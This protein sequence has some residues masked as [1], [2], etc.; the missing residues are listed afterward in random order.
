M[1]MNLRELKYILKVAE[2]RSVTGAANELHISQPAL[3]RYIHDVEEELGAKIFDRSTT[4]ISLT[5]AGECYVQSAKRIL[6]EH[7]NL[8]REIRDITNHMAGRLRIGT[9]RDRASFMMPK[10][11]PP[12]IAKYPGIETEIFTES[13]QKLREALRDGR[14]DIMILPDTWPDD[15]QNF[16]SS[17]IYTEEL[18][19]AAR[20]GTIPPESLTPNR[21]AIIPEALGGMRF[22]LLFREH[23]IR[24]FCDKY[25]RE[26]GIKPE[27][28]MEFSS[29]ITCYRM[30]AAGMGVT[31]I[32]QLTAE[33]AGAGDEAEIFSL[34]DEPV[35][36]EV[37]AFW[38]KGAYIGEP[39][40]EM[41]R[42]A[43]E[44]FGEE[45]TTG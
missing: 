41:I 16:T 27:V 45:K 15:A 14:I 44:I 4:P 10:L 19:L 32:P 40:R 2:L 33:M 39:E 3:S 43:G 18:V 37:R 22:F 31:I 11:L 20:A 1:A 9:S 21:R 5:Y 36:W 30:A 6:L 24:S 8:R 25:F 34:G 29:N 28:A 23:A 26:H 17:L 13:G 7:E 12:F 35:T 42:I 38:R